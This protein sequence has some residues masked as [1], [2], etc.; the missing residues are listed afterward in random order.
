MMGTEVHLHIN[1]N[2]DDIVAVISTTN[3][4]LDEVAID[5]EF[6]FNFK[7]ELAHYFDSETEENLVK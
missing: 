4:D 6:T 7:P 2:G 1:L 3:L 5:K